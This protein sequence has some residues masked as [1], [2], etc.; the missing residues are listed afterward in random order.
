MLFLLGSK[1]C[2][3]L[4]NSDFFKCCSLNSLSS[5]AEIA[6]KQLTDLLLKTA[7]TTELSTPDPR[8]TILELPWDLELLNDRGRTLLM[9]VSVR[10]NPKRAW[11]L[12]TEAAR[13]GHA[14]AQW[15]LTFRKRDGSDEID[16]DRAVEV[17]VLQI[18]NS[19]PLSLLLLALVLVL[20]LVCSPYVK[21]Y[22]RYLALLFFL[23]VVTP[24]LNTILPVCFSKTLLCYLPP[25]S[26]SSSTDS[27][28]VQYSLNTQVFSTVFRARISQFYSN[29]CSLPYYKNGIK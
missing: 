18:H 17:Y 26:S 19:S 4:F 6:E 10:R 13:Q 12:L 8:T 7:T 2:S 28:N 15:A 9:K 3:V 29:S 16:W 25:S 1:Q 20:V 22:Y 11:E 27:N 23:F 21:S 14:S 24:F 5:A